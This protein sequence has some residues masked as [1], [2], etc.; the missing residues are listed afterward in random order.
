M[1]TEMVV[2]EWSFGILNRGQL[3]RLL[4]DGGQLALSWKM[5][6]LM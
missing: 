2:Q 3:L 5:T 6:L 1:L 4:L